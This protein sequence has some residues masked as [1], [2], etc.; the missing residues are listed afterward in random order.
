MK[1]PFSKATLNDQNTLLKVIQISGCHMS[2]IPFRLVGSGWQWIFESLNYVRFLFKYC[3]LKNWTPFT[4]KVTAHTWAIFFPKARFSS[5]FLMFCSTSYYKKNKAFLRKFTV[6]FKSYS[7][8][9]YVLCWLF[10]AAFWK[11]IKTSK[12]FC[13]SFL[14]LKI[15]ISNKHTKQLIIKNFFSNHSFAAIQ[16]DREPAIRLIKWLRPKGLK[17]CSYVEKYAKFKNQTLKKN[18]LVHKNAMRSGIPQGRQF[19][20]LVLKWDTLYHRIEFDLPCTPM[21]I[22]HWCQ[23]TFLGPPE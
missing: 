23:K 3:K 16:V 2:R 9:L 11:L 10:Y 8:S 21:T 5:F 19:F 20:K 15:V 18:R 22:F 17:V 13:N 12:I 6:Q 7:S 14:Y 1:T 4:F